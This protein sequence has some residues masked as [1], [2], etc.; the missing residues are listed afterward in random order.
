MNQVLDNF[1]SFQRLL[2]ES[3]S[4][5]AGV[6]GLVFVGSSAD[7]L[8]VDQYSDHDF[9]LIVQNGLGESFRSRTD[10]L[11]NNQQILLAPRETEHG[12]KVLYKDGRM[13][14]YAVFEDQ[15]LELAAAN[16][17]LVALDG[18]DIEPRMAK[19]KQKSL[20]K[21]YRF[22]AEF[23][24]FLAT[25]VIGVGRNLRGEVIAAEQHIKSYA[26]E[27]LLGLVRAANPVA[28]SRQDSLN[29]FRRFEFDYPELGKELIGMLLRPTE[30]SAKQLLAFANKH[31]PLTPKQ[32]EQ[33]AAVHKLL[34]WGEIE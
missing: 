6:V 12:L 27:R 8:R 1:L 14:E 23:E 9:F 30:D 29:R 22:E 25:L 7:H 5:Q 17:Y 28:G 16:D 4:Q 15:E 13:L 3:V 20:P 18:S 19:I 32:Q 10:W 34:G 11:P 24:L 26:L 31:L 33:L 21:P 2:T